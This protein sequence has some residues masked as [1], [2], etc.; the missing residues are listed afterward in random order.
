MTVSAKTVKEAVKTTLAEDDRSRNFMMYGLEEAAE[1]QEDN[2][3]D[4]VRA[5]CEKTEV[6]QWPRL[7]SAYRMGEKKSG[8]ARPVKVQLTAALH[9]QRVLKAAHK[10]RNCEGE[11]K[12]VYL[13]PDRT[14]EEQVAHLKLVSEMKDKISNNPSKY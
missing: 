8:K 10:L 14:K 1:G 4:A 5:L 11:F 2:L 7:C 6:E 12:T 3:V 9:V 13:A